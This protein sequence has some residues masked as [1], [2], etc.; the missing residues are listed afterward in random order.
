MLALR[1]D[2]TL[3][4]PQQ[5]LRAALD[6]DAAGEAFAL[7]GVAKTEGGAVR[8]PGALMAVSESGARAG[9]LSGG[10]IDADVAAHAVQAIRT[11]EAKRLRYGTGSPFLDI[12]LPCGGAIEVV[13]IPRPSMKRLADA[14]DALASRRQAKLELGEGDTRYTADYRPP[15][16]LRLAGR[17]ADLVAMTRLATASGISCEVYTPDEDCFEALKSAAP[18]SVQKLQTPAAL[19]RN[20]DDAWT[21]FALMFHDVDWETALLA[22]A[23]E[24]PAFFVGAVGSA[25]TQARRREALADAGISAE[26]IDRVK[27][28]IGL[29]PSMRDAS[30]LA[31]S[32]LAEI[33]SEYHVEADVDA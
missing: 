20:T 13:I 29:I 22:D 30:M 6:M 10:C 15:L 24:G 27:G 32:A 21:A 9:Y 31:V 14:H 25:K 7:V 19:P 17:G 1:S 33:V 18:A 3:E 26:A 28:P 5:V 16:R 8:A 23:L 11:G 2:T 12:A 4:H